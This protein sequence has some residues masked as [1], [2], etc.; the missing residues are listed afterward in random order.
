MHGCLCS[1]HPYLLHPANMVTHPMLDEDSM[2]DSCILAVGSMSLPVLKR[3]PMF[4]A[5][6]R[7][8]FTFLLNLFVL[9]CLLWVRGVGKWPPY[10]WKSGHLVIWKPENWKVCDSM[11]PDVWESLNIRGENQC[12]NEHPSCPKCR[13]SPNY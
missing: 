1:D 10:F 8:F 9:P 3:H 4:L 7:R 13:R 6:S 12:Q 5:N 11:N 2:V